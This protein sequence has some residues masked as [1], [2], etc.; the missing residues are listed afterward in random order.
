MG[1]IVESLDWNIHKFFN[2]LD[3]VESVVDFHE[4]ERLVDLVEVEP[5]PWDDFHEIIKELEV[6]DIPVDDSFELLQEQV[7]RLHLLQS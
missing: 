1:S 3:K 4:Q 2:N 5:E 6:V 7:S